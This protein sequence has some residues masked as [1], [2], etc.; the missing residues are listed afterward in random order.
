MKEEIG[1]KISGCLNMAVLG[2]NFL[3]D[4]EKEKNKKKNR[5]TVKKYTTERQE[6][7]FH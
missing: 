6:P 1:R 7:C 3:E 2:F 5:N 4:T